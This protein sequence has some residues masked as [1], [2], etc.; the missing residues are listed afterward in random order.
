[1]GLEK[2]NV[3]SGVGLSSEIKI[4]LKGTSSEK[5]TFTVIAGHGYSGMVQKW[6]L[7]LES[8]EKTK[9]CVDGKL[10]MPSVS[11]RNVR[12]LESQDLKMYLKNV[13]GFGK[14][15]EEYSIKVDGS[16]VV[17]YEQMNLQE[18]QLLPESVKK[19]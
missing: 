8:P 17:S 4:L 19:S 3:E 11:L 1:M 7:L 5:Y 16:S 6:K 13:I 18:D 12:E 15:C 10:T 9:I 14:T 2:L